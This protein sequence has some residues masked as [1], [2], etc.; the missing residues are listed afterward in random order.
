MEP[1][2]RDEMDSLLDMLLPSAQQQL[3]KHGE[4]FPFAASID[5]AA[6]GVGN[7]AW[8]SLLPP[9][10]LALDERIAPIF[11]PIRSQMRRSPSGAPGLRRTY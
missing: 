5:Q 6:A 2:P 3:E 8:A 11:V 7:R 10:A 9:E 4:L 1:T